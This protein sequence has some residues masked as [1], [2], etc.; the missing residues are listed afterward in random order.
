MR[1]VL[2]LHI[3]Q[4]GFTLIYTTE[5]YKQFGTKPLWFHAEGWLY[6]CSSSDPVKMHLFLLHKLPHTIYVHTIHAH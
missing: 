5:H 1:R 3:M 4:F 6:S 2:Q